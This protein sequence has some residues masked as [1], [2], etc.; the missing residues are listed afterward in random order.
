VDE[1]A[2]NAS[3]LNSAMRVRFWAIR[4]RR[5]KAEWMDQPGLEPAMHIGALLGLRRINRI[6]RSAAILWP[7]IARAAAAV[8]P[9][10]LKVLDLACGVGDNMAALAKIARRRGVALEL[11]GC[12]IS[13]VAIAH[14]QSLATSHGLE[15][16]SFFLCDVL[17]QPLP[18]GFDVVMC[19]LF[20]HHLERPQATELIARMYEATERLA[21]ISDLRRTWL[22]LGLAWLGSR[23]LTRSPVV[24]TDAVLSVAGAFLESE[25][26][27]I[28][29]DCEPT[30][31]C[32]RFTRH[33]PQRWLL[34]LEKA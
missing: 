8:E 26:D 3:P 11:K 13:S 19:S 5:R 32:K 31:A 14:A 34:E 24:H 1:A 30:V 6:C 18:R 7:A 28:L 29:I 27:D 22:G 12:D 21:L 4:R 17:E 33:W 2:M 25:V 23:L 10:P 16:S 15:R 9:K 20:L